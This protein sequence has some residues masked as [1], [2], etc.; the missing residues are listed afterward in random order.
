M[1][2]KGSG[3]KLSEEDFI[4]DPDGSK[5][6]CK[7]CSAGIPSERRV[8]IGIRSAAKHLQSIEH[9]KAV[10][11]LGNA[12]R[13]Q[14]R[15]EDERRAESAA[16]GIQDFTFTHQHIHGPVPSGSSSSGLPSA[17]EVEMWARY[18]ADGAEF[19]AGN[20]AADVNVHHA[21]LQKQ[22]EV[23]G[24]LDAEGVAKALGFGGDDVAKELLAEDDEEDFLSGIMA[25]TD[26]DGGPDLENNAN[27][28]AEG[29]EAPEW[30]PY[31][32]RM[33]FLLDTLDNLPRLRISNS[34]MRVFL[35]ILK[36][37]KCKNVPSFDALRRVQKRIRSET[38]IPSIPCKSPLG[39]VFFMNDPHAIIAQDWANPTT[40]KVLHVYPEI[41]EDLARLKGGDLVIPVRWVM[42]RSKLYCDAYTVKLNDENEATIAN[43]KITLICANELADNYFDLQHQGTLPKWSATAIESGCPER[44]PNPKREIA[45]GNP[46]YTNFVDYFGD[47]VSGNRTKSWNK[48]WNAYMTHRNLPRKLL[49]QEFHVHFVSTSPNASVSEQFRE[50]KSTVESTHTDPVRVQ[51]EEGNTTCFCIH[52]NAGPSD[53]PMQSEVSAHIGGKGNRFC[54]KC[55]VGGT[56]KEKATSEGYHA[57]FEAGVPR[58][59]EKIVAELENQIKLACSG[60]LKPAKDSQTRTGVKDM[61]TQHWINHLLSRFKITAELVQWTLDNRDSIYSAF[62]TTKGFDPTKDTPVELLHTILLGVVKYIWHISHTPWSP[63]KKKVYSHRL[64]ATAT[65]GLS[66]HAIRANYIMQYAGSLIGQQFKTIVQTNVFH[67]HGLVTEHQFMAW[68]ATGELAA[69]LWVPEIRNLA[70]YRRDIR[71]AVANVLDIFALI[72]PS[73]IITKIKYHLLAHIED[74]VVEFGPLIGVATEIFECFNAIFRYCSILSNHLAPSRDIALQLGDQE[75]L[76]HRL[77]GGWWL[78]NQGWRRA[79]TG[80]R[81]FMSAHPMLQKLLGWTEEKL[82]KHGH[83]KLL[84]LKRGLKV[85]PPLSIR[86]TTAVHALNYGHYTPEPNWIRCTSVSAIDKDSTISGRISDILTND[87]RATIV[88]LELFQVLSVRDPLYGMPVLVRRNSVITFQIVPFKNIKFKINVQHDCYTAKCEAT[89]ERLRMQERVESDNVENFIVHGSLDRFIINSHAFHNAHLLRATLPRDLLAPI[90]LFEDRKEKHDEFAEALRQKCATKIAKKKAQ[91]AGKKKATTKKRKAPP[92]PGNEDEDA[93]TATA[94][95]PS[96][97]AKRSRRASPGTEQSAGCYRYDYR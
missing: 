97:P 58:A 5:V 28:D 85:R 61:Y 68:K 37:A 59:K 55:E 80:V 9:F 1:P 43:E 64:Q 15:L 4:V 25:N 32:T 45:G 81:G 92:P 48:H 21:R 17:A 23:F 87:A 26:L 60:V 41:P 74:D 13:Q 39:N 35:W 67:V 11:R 2:P 44:M 57:L 83:T 46:L 79:G 20:D 18:E 96:K 89:G 34:L 75:G 84:P 49:Q 72:D 90:P 27:T 8:K 71:V 10:E 19:D 70:E 24:L 51:D 38:G 30:F 14:E 54:Q 40:R 62:L 88:V 29:S 16:S 3:T 86:D 36:E 42:F 91:P 7:V 12:K 33:M 56:Q 93:A 50:F 94:A 77:T 47:D 6:E 52:V 66:I 65:D 73:K 76:K 22:A 95:G 69:L 63:E 82:L 78:S 53:N 31:P